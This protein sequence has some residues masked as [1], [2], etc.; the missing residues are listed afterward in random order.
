MQETV[1]DI[2][3]STNALSFIA[4]MLF[5]FLMVIS[6]F[7]IHEIILISMIGFL[8]AESVWLITSFIKDFNK[9]QNLR[10]VS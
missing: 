1:S 3:D 8:I 7:Y 2:I 5:G 6:I 9:R 10:E 4:G